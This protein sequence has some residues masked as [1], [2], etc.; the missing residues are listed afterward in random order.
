MIIFL[1]IYKIQNSFFYN[2]IKNNGGALYFSNSNINISIENSGFSNCK[3][4]IGGAIYTIINQVSFIF[5]CIYN[6]SAINVGQSFYF[7][8]SK[9]NYLFYNSISFCSHSRNFDKWSLYSY[10]NIHDISYINSSYNIINSNTPGIRIYAI[11]KSIFKYFTITNGDSSEGAN[12]NCHGSASHFLI[13]KGNIA[14]NPIRQSYGLVFTYENA[15]PIIKDCV[16][17]NNT[18]NT[19]VISWVN[20]YVTFLNCSFDNSQSLIGSATIND[21]GFKENW[22]T[23]LIFHHSKSCKQFETNLKNSYHIQNH[24][25]ILSFFINSF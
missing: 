18:G 24:M 16:F 7:H 15:K 5:S 9:Q 12:I 20:S 6:C 2:L 13:E 22:N 14:H 3:A 19:I 21:C 17:R 10:A 11:E 4:E 1:F 8:L 25:F 23:L